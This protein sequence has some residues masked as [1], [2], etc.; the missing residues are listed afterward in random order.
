MRVCQ[1]KRE[2]EK[3]REREERR[4]REKKGEREREKEG[5]RE[6]EKEGEREREGREERER[7]REREKASP[8]RP[9]KNEFFKTFGLFPHVIRPGKLILRHD[10]VQNGV[11]IFDDLGV[12]M[13]PLCLR[14]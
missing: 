14:L 8:S 11:Q 1:R 9:A 6:R 5:E 13:D 2:R 12:V 10:K 7:E 4:E 3:E